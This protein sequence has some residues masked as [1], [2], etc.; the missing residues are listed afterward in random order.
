[1]ATPSFA[2]VQTLH[3]TAGRLASGAEYQWSHFGKCNCGHLAQTATRISARDIHRTAH[4]KLS[5]WSEIPDDFCPQTGVLIDR[6]IDTLFELGLTNTDLRH[7]EDLT[8]P[9]VLARLPGGRRYLQRNQRDDVIVYLRTWAQLLADEL[10]S[11]EFSSEFGVRRS[12]AA[13][14]A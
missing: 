13:A 8:D 14:T 11:A 5:E 10:T 3:E 9:E 7:L 4:R 12:E 6:V 2:L 1:M